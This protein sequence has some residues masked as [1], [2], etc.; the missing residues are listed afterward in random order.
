MK[1]KDERAALRARVQATH[2]GIAATL[3]AQPAARSL[4][5][6]IRQQLAALLAWT[7]DDALPAEADLRRITVGHIALREIG[8][9]EEDAPPALRPLRAALL[10]I[11]DDVMSF[12]EPFP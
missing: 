11:Q 7:E 6:P 8:E 3:A 12:Y 1:N 9:L 10:E 4:L 2:D 5:E